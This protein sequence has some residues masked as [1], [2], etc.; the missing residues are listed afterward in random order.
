MGDFN[1]RIGK[2]QIQKT[3]VHDVLKYWNSGKCNSAKNRSS[4]G[5]R[6]TAKAN[7][8]TDIYETNNLEILIEK[9]K[10]DTRNLFY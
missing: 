6:C 3:H 7:K 1:C 2:R 4:K 10:T 9:F 8:P 5:K